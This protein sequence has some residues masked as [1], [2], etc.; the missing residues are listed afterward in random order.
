MIVTEDMLTSILNKLNSDVSA[1]KKQALNYA[2]DKGFQSLQWVHY[3]NREHDCIDL[4]GKYNLPS[5]PTVIVRL[6]L[7]C[8]TKACYNLYMA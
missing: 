3:P 5:K 7:N 6:L 2:K 4:F 1:L 8:E